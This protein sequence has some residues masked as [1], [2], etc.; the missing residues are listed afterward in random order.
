MS[1]LKAVVDAAKA[2]SD[3]HLEKG[4]FGAFFCGCLVHSFL[5][6][7]TNTTPKLDA[8]VRG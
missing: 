7:E 5:L 3:N 4:R 2:G 8:K 1:G 6:L